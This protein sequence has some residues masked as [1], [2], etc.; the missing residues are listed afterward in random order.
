MANFIQEFKKFAVRGNVIDLAIGVIVGGAF[1]KIVSSFVADIIMPP[2]ST[3]LGVVNFSEFK[4]TLAAET[5][6][7][8]AV[9]MNVGAFVQSILDF[10]LIAIALFLFIRV[11]NRIQQAA[12]KDTSTESPKTK[13]QELLTEIRDLL[14]QQ[15]QK[16]Q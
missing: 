14:K 3:F 6:K 5:L 13:D 16:P 15:N 1:G 11:I 4:V 2:I 12:A 10:I 7:H 9:T 8:P